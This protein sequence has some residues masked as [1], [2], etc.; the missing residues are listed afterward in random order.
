MSEENR[1]SAYSAQVGDKVSAS[2]VA[3]VQL[4]KDLSSLE[5]QAMLYAPSGWSE[6]RYREQV[7]D[8]VLDQYNVMNKYRAFMPVD[9]L[10]TPSDFSITE[11]KMGV[12]LNR[13][14]CREKAVWL[15]FKK[16]ADDN[17]K[18]TSLWHFNPKQYIIP[19]LE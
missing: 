16:I 8:T 11:L 7:I 4:N 10:K 5:K 15:G 17:G 2:V 19:G 3:L 6:N 13:R 1:Q 9:M 14:Y 12:L 18:D